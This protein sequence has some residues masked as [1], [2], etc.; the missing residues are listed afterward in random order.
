M[1]HRS[2]QASME[3]FN[4]QIGGVSIKELNLLELEM[5]KALDFRAYISHEELSKVLSLLVSNETSDKEEATARRSKKRGNEG[6]QPEIEVGSLP[7]KLHHDSKSDQ[8]LVTAGESVCEDQPSGRKATTAVV[9]LSCLLQESSTS[10]LD[11]KSLP[12]QCAI[13]VGGT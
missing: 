12:V 1:I 6:A 3:T 7:A 11:G 2:N 10:S 8:V 13:S 9:K 4:L 5:L